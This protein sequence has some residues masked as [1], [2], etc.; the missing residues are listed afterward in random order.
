MKLIKLFL[1]L[2]PII[3]IGQKKFSAVREEL[4][5]SNKYE[6]VYNYENNYAVFRTFNGRM[7]LLDSIGNVVIKPRYEYIHNKEELKNLY[8]V[9]TTI[10]K[11]FKRGYI[12]LKGNIKIPLEYDDI[13]HL[14][15]NLIRVTKNNKTGVIDTLN[16][17]IV[18]L[19]FDN[20]M[21]H[22]GI[23]YTQS[24]NVVDIFD[25]SGK[26]LTH[27]NAKDIDYVTANRTI[28]TLQ[29]N[30]NL[31]INDEGK[32]ILEPIKNHKFEKIVNSDSYIIINTL[33]RKKGVIN[34]KGKYEI[35]CKYDDIV[36]NQSTYIAV[37]KR[38][39][40]LITKN[41][42]VLKPFIYD[43]IYPVNYKE[44]N[45]FQNQFSARIGDLEGIL[46]PYSEKE[47]IPLR[48]KNIQT[49]SNYYIVTNSEN[50]NGLFSEQGNSII[51]EDYEFCNVSKNKIFATKQDKNYLITLVDNSYSEVE[52]PV[53]A[54]VKKG[55][56]YMG[57]SQSNFQIF[58]TGNK[59]GVINNKNEIAVACEYDAIEDIYSTSEFIVKKNQK[60]GVINAQ[61]QITLEIKYDSFNRMKE[62]IRFEIKNQK[63]KKNYTVNY[64]SQY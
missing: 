25:F 45:L 12:D 57:Y 31:I 24:K 23:I 63:E 5:K 46:D 41:D 1:L 58:R 40:G 32:T 36:P 61:N 53:D 10:N 19:K 22:S 13:F 33:T 11:K 29:D 9:G 26:Q 51:N 48:Y 64:S 34:S 47:I 56:S 2:L 35:E 60:Y 42:S 62:Y 30:R 3:A 27:Y 28:V 59:F 54:F 8:E 39:Y 50:K 6:Y 14:D 7:G 20:I 15:K 4:I 37:D 17:I 16:N 43:G 44:D 38:K 49:F 55:Q 18:P 52:I 21:D